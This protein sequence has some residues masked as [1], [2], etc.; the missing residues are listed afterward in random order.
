MHLQSLEVFKERV[1]VKLRGMVSRHDG[2]GSAAGV[3]D[4]RGLFQLNKV[5][6]S[7]L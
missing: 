6:D 2:D 3:D 5:F 7:I 4:L 1:D